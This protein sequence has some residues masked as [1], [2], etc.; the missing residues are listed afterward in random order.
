M[1]WRGNLSVRDQSELLI[2]VGDL[3]RSRFKDRHNPWSYRIGIVVEIER[4]GTSPGVWVEWPEKGLYWS[5]TQQ[6]E[7]ISEA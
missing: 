6:L 4:M 2:H 5:P 1:E 7:V 3:V